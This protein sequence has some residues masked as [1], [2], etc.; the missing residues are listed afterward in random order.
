MMACRFLSFF[1]SHSSMKTRSGGSSSPYQKMYPLSWRSMRLVA[2]S[3][4]IQK[5]KL[6]FLTQ[7][8]NRYLHTAYIYIAIVCES[9]TSKLK[10]ETTATGIACNGHMVH[11]SKI[12]FLW[13]PK[14]HVTNSQLML[15][16]HRPMD[17][18]LGF[19][20]A[21]RISMISDLEIQEVMV[22][23]GR[24]WSKHALAPLGLLCW[25][26]APRYKS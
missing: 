6:G 22:R 25:G 4:K 16:F 3:L 8:A 18:R 24:R 23:L 14:S 1:R 12:H 13:L 7:Y 20:T 26:I 11:I 19:I 15:V 10:W 17:R 21:S 2:A 5:K 9:E